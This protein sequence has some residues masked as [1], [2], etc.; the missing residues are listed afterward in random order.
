VNK[1]HFFR[2]VLAV[3][4]AATLSLAVQ[5]QDKPI[6]VGVTAGPHAQLLGGL[7]SWRR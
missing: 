4:A 6:K 3:A 2:N 1:R 5:A 7:W